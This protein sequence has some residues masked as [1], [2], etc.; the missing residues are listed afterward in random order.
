L[1]RITNNFRFASS[2]VEQNIE[3]HATNGNP[4][5]AN[6]I[7]T[8]PVI[9]VGPSTTV[10]EIAALLFR[11]RISAVPVLDEGRLVGVVSEGDLLH[12][13]EIGTDRQTRTG[14]WWLR[15]FGEDRSA[16]EYAKSHARRARDVMT[17]EVI[18]IAPDAP[19]AEVAGLLETH[20]IKRVPVL[21]GGELVG[22]VSR[23]NLVQ[24]MALAAHP[25]ARIHPSNDDAIRGRLLS[26]LE[27]QPWWRPAR[28]S[29]LVKEGVVH[30]W[31]TID[32]EGE[33]DAARVA[34]ENISGVHGVDDRRRLFQPLPPMA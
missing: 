5:K 3:I 10:A 23:A 20:G 22:I 18:S 29:V 19:L 28:S 30:Y 34:A 14:S 7:M 12:R 33:R 6:D 4:M 24:A 21:R 11:E 31:G 1:D 8:T 13:P 26:E 9:T 2:N 32:S 17:R 27:R 15:L 16:S 25:A